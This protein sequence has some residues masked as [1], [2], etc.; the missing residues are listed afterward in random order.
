M[1][2]TSFAALP[3]PPYHAVIF[4]SLR[5]AGDA[6]AY[7]EASERRLALARK[8]PGFLGAQSARGAD[9]F[10]L[11]DSYWRDEAAIPAWREHAEHAQVRRYGRTAWYDHFEVRAARVERAFGRPGTPST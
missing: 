2:G 9:R 3:P 8:Q 7:E 11:T 10:G 6:E 1:T 4:S 5:S